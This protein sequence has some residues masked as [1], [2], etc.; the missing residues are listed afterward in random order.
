MQVSTKL[1]GKTG[2]YCIH[3]LINNK[4]YVG[5]SKNIYY[6]LHRHKSDLIKNKHKNPYL[7]NAWNK[8]GEKNFQCYILEL[9]K[10]KDSFKLEEK[11]IKEC[12]DYNCATFN[13]QRIQYSKKTRQKMSKVKKEQYA[14]GLKNAKSVPILQYD[15]DGNFIR[16]FKSIAEAERILKISHSMLLKVLSGKFKRA[17]QFQFKRKDDSK[18]IGKYQKRNYSNQKKLFK[19]IKIENLKTGEIIIFESFKA[20]A[21][22]FKVTPPVIS[23]KLN[24]SK[25][26][27]YKNKYKIGL[28][29]SDE[30][31]ETPK[32]DNQQPS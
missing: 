10:L 32:K 3:N 16:E 22:Y 7:Q 19:P 30:L 9:C 20:C 6:R 26:N 23:V 27:I 2:I 4:K 14:N 21:K 5:K 31:L 13:D 17:K 24:K 8:H 25:N 28:V 11:Y 29:K 12:G 18:I 1:I 15:L